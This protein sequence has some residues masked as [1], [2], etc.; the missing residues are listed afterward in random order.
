MT[1]SM[2]SRWT[3]NWMKVFAAS[4]FGVGTSVNEADR[5]P[6]FCLDQGC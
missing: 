2:P 3:L 1:A 5:L 4:E 6:F